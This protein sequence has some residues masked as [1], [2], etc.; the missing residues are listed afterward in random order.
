MNKIPFVDLYA[1]YLSIR[2]E[3]DKAIS[4]VISE[5]SFVRGPQVRVGWFA[6]EALADPGAGRGLDEDE[7]GGQAVAVPMCAVHAL[8]L[9]GDARQCRPHGRQVQDHAARVVY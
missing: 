8:L 9:E 5:S 1:Q 6:G 4:Q 7:F 2:E 3:L